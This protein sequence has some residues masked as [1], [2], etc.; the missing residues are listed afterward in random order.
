MMCYHFSL[1]YVYIYSTPIFFLQGFSLDH[2]MHR[3]VAIFLGA[4]RSAC[5]PLP[6]T[7]LHI[8]E[9]F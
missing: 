7:A 3:D 4:D 5:K 6:L 2:L 1:I 9:V 8:N